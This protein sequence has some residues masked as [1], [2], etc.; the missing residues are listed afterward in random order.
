MAAQPSPAQ[1]WPVLPVL[2]WRHLVPPCQSRHRPLSDGP[3]GQAGRGDGQAPGGDG[4]GAGGDGEAPGG[5]G[6]SSGDIGRAHRGT[7][8]VVAVTPV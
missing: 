8:G 3:A 4:G 6:G 1:H 5:D 2:S 7:G